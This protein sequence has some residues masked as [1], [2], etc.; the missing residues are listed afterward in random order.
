MIQTRFGSEVKITKDEG[1][2]WLRIMQVDDKSET[3]CHISELK[4][5]NGIAEIMEAATAAKQ[6]YPDQKGK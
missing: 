2:G 5:T 4:A 3:T 6:K 1:G